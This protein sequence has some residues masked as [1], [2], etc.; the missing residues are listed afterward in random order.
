[1]VASVYGIGSGA[2]LDWLS[3]NQRYECRV[4]F[5]GIATQLR[6]GDESH[7][8]K[9]FGT[10]AVRKSPR[11]FLLSELQRDQKTNNSPLKTN[12]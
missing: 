11:L 3:V 1:M 6:T 5:P 8:Y 7:D 9:L 12:N 10:G 2:V 4:A